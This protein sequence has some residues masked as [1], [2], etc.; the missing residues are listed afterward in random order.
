MGKDLNNDL[1]VICI[2][3]AIQKLEELEGPKIEEYIEILEH[4]Q[5]HINILL[6]CA[7]G[8]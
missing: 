8:W 1:R 7:L 6:D 2:K 4:I 5:Q 3:E